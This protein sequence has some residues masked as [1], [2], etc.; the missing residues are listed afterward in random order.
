MALRGYV[1]RPG[2]LVCREDESPVDGPAYPSA[3]R[4]APVSAGTIR[5]DADGNGGWRGSA[6][7]EPLTGYHQADRWAVRAYGEG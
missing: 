3:N 2:T 6:S 4:A 5:T 1:F 7:R